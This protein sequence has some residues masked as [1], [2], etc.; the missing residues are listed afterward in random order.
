MAGH[1]HWANIQYRKAAVDK[2][3]GKILSK[4]ARLIISAAKQGGGNP[5][6]NLKLRYA[7]DKARE[8]SM[9]KDTI[10]RAIK[11]GT[12]TLEDSNYEEITYEGY[13]P[14]GV[15][16]LIDGLT[17]NRHRTAPEMKK[18]FEVHGGNL[19]M[20]GS[21]SWMFEKKGMFLFK[22]SSIAEDKLMEMA[23]DAGA[24][25]VASTEGNFQV[26]CDPTQFLKIKEIFQG[27][28]LTWESAEVT[29]IPKNTIP[30]NA[31]MAKNVLALME[32]LDNHD[33][34]Q[35]TYGNF[36]IPPEVFKEI[37]K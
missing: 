11:K 32:E 31:E 15:A 20:T 1:S 2:K 12:G 13:G 14:G 5:E 18:I 3:K 25:D 33:D 37:G 29:Q 28:G 4:I 36:E 7:L 30:L 17:D 6:S 22:Q 35:Q 19:G 24:E 10:E 34:V 8:V 9:P 27:K 26:T 21:V 23:L 16:I